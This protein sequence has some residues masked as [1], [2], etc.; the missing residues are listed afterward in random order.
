MIYY[1]IGTVIDDIA[2]YPVFYKDLE[3]CKQDLD[4]EL[5]KFTSDDFENAPE[6]I[7]RIFKVEVSLAKGV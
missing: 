4:A 3:N 6:M 7:P 2:Q 5:E 1:F